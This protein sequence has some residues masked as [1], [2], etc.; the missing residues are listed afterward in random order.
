[1]KACTSTFNAPFNGELD[2]PHQCANRGNHSIHYCG[3][4]LE[5]V[6]TPAI[7]ESTLRFI[8]TGEGGVRRDRPRR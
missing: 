1:M 3:C 7:S 5:W 6:E 8:E 4:G 2:V